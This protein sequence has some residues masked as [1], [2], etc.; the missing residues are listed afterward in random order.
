MPCA[1][2]QRL[3]QSKATLRAFSMASAPPSTK[4]RWGS[5]GSPRTRA[6]V[7]TKRAIGTL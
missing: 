1:S 2:F 4:N 3:F 7:S 5:A 6:K